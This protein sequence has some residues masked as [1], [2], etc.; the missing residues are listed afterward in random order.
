MRRKWR[1]ARTLPSTWSKITRTANA[2]DPNTRTLLTEVDVPNPQNAL[3]PGMYLQVKFTATRGVSAVMIPSAALVIRNDG[4]FVP[5]LDQQNQVHYRKVD[6][7][8]DYGAEVEVLT[9]LDGGETVVVYPGDALPDG[10]EVDPVQAA[11]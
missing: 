11:K 8:R 4:A 1:R 6:R 2:L 9:G 5:V 3:Q 7:G 10:Q